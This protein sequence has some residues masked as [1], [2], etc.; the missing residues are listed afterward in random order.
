MKMSNYKRD[1]KAVLAGLVTMKNNSLV[2]KK[3]CFIL[4]PV[5]WEGTTLV[6]ASGDGGFRISGPVGIFIGKAYS[7]MTCMA[8]IGYTP[9]SMNK[10][11]VDG[12]PMV[13]MH[14]PA[15]CQVIDNLEVVRDGNVPYYVDH[16][17]TAKGVSIPYMTKDDRLN[18]M[19]TTGASS[20]LFGLP[21]QAYIT[22]RT[23]HYLRTP[24]NLSKLTNGSSSGKFVPISIMDIANAVP[25]NLGKLSG[26]YM[27][28]GMQEILIGSNTTNNSNV[29]DIILLG[30]ELNG[31][32]R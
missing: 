21:N 26:S 12:I 7:T 10:V 13:A 29:D 17:V 20:G 31:N 11:E 3:D 9:E 32:R 22:L 19:T 18:L 1:G 15:G 24:G 27:E 23:N 25:S 28:D 5:A 4:Y 30:G 6:T 14:F 8:Q 2:A 16:N